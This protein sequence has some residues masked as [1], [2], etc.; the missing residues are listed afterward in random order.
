MRIRDAVIYHVDKESTR[1]RVVEEVSTDPWHRDEP[2]P[3][4]A[5]EVEGEIDRLV[6]RGVLTECVVDNLVYGRGFLVVTE[7]C[8]RAVEGIR[9]LNAS[10]ATASDQ[11]D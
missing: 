10:K 11:S 2:S 6:R 7:W 3:W 8:P 5:E 1:R 9:A 4:T